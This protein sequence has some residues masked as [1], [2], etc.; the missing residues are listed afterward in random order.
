MGVSYLMVCKC[1][2]FYLGKTI[3][4][5]RQRIGDY[6]YYSSSGK[7]TTIGCHIELHHKFDLM[8]IRFLCLEVVHQSSSGG[9]WDRVIFQRETMWNEC[10]NVTT[11][12]GLNKIIIYK[13]FLWYILF[14]SIP[15]ALSHSFFPPLTFQ[16]PLSPPF[17]TPSPSSPLASQHG[18]CMHAQCGEP[19][20]VTSRTTSVHSWHPPG[21]GA[22]KRACPACEHSGF[23]PKEEA[24]MHHKPGMHPDLYT[25]WPLLLDTAGVMLILISIS[26]P[27]ISRTNQLACYLFGR[28]KHDHR[29]Q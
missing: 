3:C 7:L 27:C 23:L 4:E 8:A 10:L 18:S 6:L 24:L 15:L 22:H 16:T 1:N 5:L 17:F 2:A 21:C 26:V 14:F 28:A 19:D 20:P 11:P 9:D 29:K 12:P 25:D 13:P